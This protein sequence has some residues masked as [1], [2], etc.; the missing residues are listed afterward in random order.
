VHEEATLVTGTSA[1]RG[2]AVEAAC[3]MGNG[4]GAQRDAEGGIDPDCGGAARRNGSI[5]AICL[6]CGEG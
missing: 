1:A 6:R 3:A 2:K 4:H 5:R